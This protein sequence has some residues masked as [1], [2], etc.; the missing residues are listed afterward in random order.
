[1]KTKNILILALSL[2]AIIYAVSLVTESNNTTIEN[3]KLINVDLAL[4][5]GFN[6][7]SLVGYCDNNPVM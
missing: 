1:M 7:G 5:W 6:I 3:T 2:M 4:M